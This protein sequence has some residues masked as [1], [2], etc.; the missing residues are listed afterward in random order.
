L[1]PAQAALAASIASW[2]A[3]VI[4]AGTPVRMRS[5][6]TP[7]RPCAVACSAR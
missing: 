4:M 6:L 7:Q 1:P 5:T 3:G 2:N